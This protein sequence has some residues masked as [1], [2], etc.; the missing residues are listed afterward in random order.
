MNEEVVINDILAGNVN[1]YEEIV[2]EYQD[3]VAN[4]CFKIGGP[5]ID[6]AEMTQQVFVELYYA[7]PRF[8]FQSKLSTFIYRLTV[9]V[10]CKEIKHNSRWV[11]SQD[12]SNA[13]EIAS[14]DNN[15]EQAIVQDE[16]YRTLYAAIGRLHSEQRTALVLYT[17]ND[18]S[19]NDIADVMQCTVAKVES[20][21]FR[22][23]KNLKKMLSNE[24]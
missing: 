7:L 12:D 15:V 8:K 17:F 22:A 9:N 13:P 20:L 3:I 14:D 1:R 4:L 10:V 16:R 18:F 2:R 6:V 19:Y 23:R 11:T 5:K 24:G 21:I